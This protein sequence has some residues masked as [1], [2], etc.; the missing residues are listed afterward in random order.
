M[1][2]PAICSIGVVPDQ[3]R[4]NIIKSFPRKAKGR[5]RLRGDL[6]MLGQPSAAFLRSFAAPG[7]QRRAISATGQV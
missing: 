6:I 5:A 1:M 7:I 2:E 3:I 4:K